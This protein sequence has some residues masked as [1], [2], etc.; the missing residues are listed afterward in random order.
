MLLCH[1]SSCAPGLLGGPRWFPQHSSCKTWDSSIETS[2]TSGHTSGIL[3]PHSIA[4]VLFPCSW[5]K[6]CCN[7]EGAGSY[8]FWKMMLLLLLGEGHW[9]P[10]PGTAHWGASQF[11]TCGYCICLPCFGTHSK[12]LPGLVL[13]TCSVWLLPLSKQGTGHICSLWNR[14]YWEPTSWSCC[15]PQC[16]AL[17]TKCRFSGTDTTFFQPVSL[18]GL[19]SG[20]CQRTHWLWHGLSTPLVRHEVCRI[21]RIHQPHQVPGW[22]HDL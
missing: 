10:K 4:A 18:G 17:G 2:L 6:A 22:S 14:K 16:L 3:E 1:S 5:Q 13:S 7:A 20:S 19:A 12:S 8:A 11:H 15:W 21:W 9:N